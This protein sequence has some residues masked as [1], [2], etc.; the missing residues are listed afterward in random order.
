MPGFGSV[1][2]YPVAALPAFYPSGPSMVADTAT[3]VVSSTGNTVVL[4]GT[5][6]SWTPGT[7]G[8]PTF[9]IS[10]SGSGASITAQT[11]DSSTQATLTVDAGT[12]IG[13]TITIN[14]PDNSLDVFI[15]IV[16][17]PGS[18]LLLRMMTEGLYAG[19]HS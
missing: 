13:D 7:P 14:D 1:A 16:A 17:A 19:M 12:G 10:T 11:V 9:G 6:T 3:L 4:T 2:S 5:G 18:G 8:S 15:G